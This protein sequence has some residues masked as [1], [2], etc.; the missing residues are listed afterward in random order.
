[1]P[2]SALDSRATHRRPTR[3]VK[4]GSVVIGGGA[5]IVVQSMCATKTSDVEAT[6]AQVDQLARAGG[7]A[8]SA[9]PPTRRAIAKPWPKSGAERPSIFP[10]ISRKTTG[11]PPRWRRW[12]TRF[13]ITRATFITM[14]A[15]GPGK[16]KFASSS[17]WRAKTTVRL[18]VGVNCGSVDPSKTIS[19]SS[20][21]GEADPLR[22]HARKRPRT[23]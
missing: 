16:T 19:A 17:T 4:V 20:E 14:N 2:P 11:S 7:R 18:R 21:A 8:S 12:S 5:P 23:L 3:P 22:P 15:I 1:M 6:V 10:S 9:S 13:A